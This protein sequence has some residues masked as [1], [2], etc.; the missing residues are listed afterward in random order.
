MI[1]EL[2][3]L[4][5][6]RWRLRF[7]RELAHPPERVWQAI[8][9]PEHLTAWFPQRVE[10]DLLTPGAPLRFE[11]SHDTPGFGGQVL[12][13]EPPT[14]LEFT[15]GPDTLRLEITPAPRGCT[16]TLTDTIGEL[17]KAARD[18]AGW[19]ACL[20][21]LAAALDGTPPPPSGEIWQAVHGDYVAAFGPEAATIGPPE[22]P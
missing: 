17:G 20:D 13:V 18:A 22:L 14:L 5:T 9:R 16:L 19:H 3:T 10:G 6:G 12:A 15:W 8:T 1:G 2:D 4:G 7:T 21:L 11:H